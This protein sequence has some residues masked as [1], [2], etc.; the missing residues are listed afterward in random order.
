MIEWT[1]STKVTKTKSL[2]YGMKLRYIA[3]LLTVNKRM[4]WSVWALA[5]YE[6]QWALFS[7]FSSKLV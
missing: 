1:A 4:T 5:Q 7:H 2:S 3:I 6:Q